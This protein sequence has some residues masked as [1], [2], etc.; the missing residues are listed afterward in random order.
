MSDSELRYTRRGH[1]ETLFLPSSGKLLINR[2]ASPGKLEAGQVSSKLR[3]RKHTAGT[4]CGRPHDPCC[5]PPIVLGCL[6]VGLTSWACST[7]K[8]LRAYASAG[9]MRSTMDGGF[10][11]RCCLG[12]DARRA[13]MQSATAQEACG[14]RE[15]R[16]GAQ[17]SAAWTRRG[18]RLEEQL[19][20]AC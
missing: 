18:Q 17:I 2:P 5:L 1:N 8:S 7:I 6:L 10:S 3:R 15:A 11:W 9:K 16:A 19:P 4:P 13:P 14:P 20:H 12:M